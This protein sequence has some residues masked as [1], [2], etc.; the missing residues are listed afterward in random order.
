MATQKR[1]VGPF[2]GTV[3]PVN[4]P[5]LYKRRTK[6]GNIVWSWWTGRIWCKFSSRKSKAVEKGEVESRSQYQSLPW[7]GRAR[8][9]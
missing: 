4:G 8:R 7:F 9:T 2:P 1:L 5:G 6:R 3:K